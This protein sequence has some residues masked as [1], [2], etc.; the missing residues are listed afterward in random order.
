[1]NFNPYLTI[2]YPDLKNEEL[3]FDREIG[4]IFL[5]N[6]DNRLGLRQH[7]VN[8]TIEDS[9]SVNYN[10]RFFKSIF[11]HFIGIDWKE[12]QSKDMQDKKI[13]LL[14]IIYNGFLSL[15]EEFDWDKEII[16]DTYSK[17]LNDNYLFNYKTEP[18]MNRQ[19]KIESYIK[20]DIHGS[21]AKISA[22]AMNKI[23]NETTIKELLITDEDN[24]SWW[25]EIREYGWLDNSHFGLKLK[26]GEIWLTLNVETKEIK[27]IFKPKNKTLEQLETFMTELQTIRS[28]GDE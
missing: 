10:R 11:E 16:I 27:N 17:S 23:T 4:W 18:K 13:Q 9:N 24:L 14:K 7:R 19:K 25:R 8:I 1:M 15:A 12:F 22:I 3:S 6:L 20:L 2:Y 28:W 21:I 26:K 5:K